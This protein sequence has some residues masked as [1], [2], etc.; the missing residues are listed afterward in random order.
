VLASYNADVQWP[1]FKFFP[2]FCHHDILKLIF[3]IFHIPD[4]LISR[5]VHTW[6][7]IFISRW[8]FSAR[9]SQSTNKISPTHWSTA[10]PCLSYIMGCRSVNK[11]LSIDSFR[12]WDVRHRVFHTFSH[13]LGM[14]SLQTAARQALIL[15]H[16]LFFV[17]NN[18]LQSML[19][20]EILTSHLMSASLMI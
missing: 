3:V 8:R 19:K 16:K 11:Q 6:S 4:E 1:Q 10:D 18:P 13:L 14:H 17:K 5:L 9:Y 15:Y 7:L 2:Y 20:N 12:N